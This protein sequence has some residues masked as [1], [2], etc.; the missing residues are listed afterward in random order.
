LSNTMAMPAVT[1]KPKRRIRNEPA[2]RQ[3]HRPE[4]SE[5]AVVDTP[6]AEARKPPE[7]TAAHVMVGS[8]PPADPDWTYLDEL[9][10]GSGT[11]KGNPFGGAIIEDQCTGWSPDSGGRVDTTR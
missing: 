5:S 9:G 2:E 1:G 6:D 10:K 4:P 8:S 3:H 11:V 7:V